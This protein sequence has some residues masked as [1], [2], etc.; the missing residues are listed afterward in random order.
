MKKLH[1]FFYF[2]KLCCAVYVELNQLDVHLTSYIKS[3]LYVTPCDAKILHYIASKMRCIILINNNF[4]CY[5]QNG[6]KFLLVTSGRCNF[7]WCQNWIASNIYIKTSKLLHD[8]RGLIHLQV[9]RKLTVL[10]DRHHFSECFVCRS[11]NKSSL[12]ITIF[13]IKA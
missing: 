9:T 5:L 13:V 6:Q 2:K 8:C 3:S 11:E 7:I 12:C 1:I 4:L 10:F